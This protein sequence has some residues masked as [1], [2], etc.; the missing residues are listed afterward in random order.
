M[1]R[2]YS[3]APFFI[4]CLA[5]L[6]L[7]LRA[8]E[9]RKAIAFAAAAGVVLGIGFGFR[10]DL[11]LLLPVGIVLL[12]VGSDAALHPLRQRALGVVTFTAISLVTA[13]PIFAYGVDGSFAGF[14]IQGATKPFLRL[15]GVQSGSYDLGWAYSD[16]LTL[17]GITADLRPAGTPAT[18]EQTGDAVCQAI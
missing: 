6:L 15:L 16:E 3:K 13:L 2:D 7:A 1:V 12:A 4:W 10:A 8:G 9:K 14:E 18:T 11:L 5:L 17:S